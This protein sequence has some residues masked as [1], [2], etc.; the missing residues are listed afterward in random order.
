MNLLE[1]EWVAR[2]GH[3]FR[4]GTQINAEVVGD[5]RA[6]A[7]LN[8]AGTERRVRLARRTGKKDVNRDVLGGT[9]ALSIGLCFRTFASFGVSWRLAA[10]NNASRLYAFSHPLGGAALLRRLVQAEAAASPHQMFA[11]TYDVLNISG[12]AYASR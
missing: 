2:P 3:G 11:P 7:T 8:E 9:T 10:L 4:E 1:G 12:S 6:L 5:S